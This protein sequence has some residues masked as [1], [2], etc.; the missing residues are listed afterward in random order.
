M[1]FRQFGVFCA[2]ALLCGSCVVASADPVTSA[3]WQEYRSAQGFK[4]EMPAKPEEVVQDLPSAPGQKMY[5][6]TLS[7]KNGGMLAFASDIAPI[8]AAKAEE[9]LNLSRDTALKTMSATIA[10]EQKEK[11]GQ[12]PALRFEYEATNGYQG[13]M[14]LVVAGNRLYQINAVGPAGFAASPEAKRFLNSFALTGK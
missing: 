2:A 10:N 14:R 11:V 1:N 7:Y 13:T 8:D 9:V 5:A 3:N 4:I 12:Y 6:A